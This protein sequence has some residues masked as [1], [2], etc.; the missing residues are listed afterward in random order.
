VSHEKGADEGPGGDGEEALGAAHEHISLSNL[1]HS[2]Q[3]LAGI[4]SFNIGTA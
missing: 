1:R 4:L 2:S 3:A